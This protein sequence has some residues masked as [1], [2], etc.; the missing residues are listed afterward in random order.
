VSVLT[1]HNDNARTGQNLF[2]GVLTPVNVQAA[3]LGKLFADAVDG[4]VYA[5]PLYMPNVAIPGR[6]L[7]RQ[8]ARLLACDHYH[9]RFAA[10]QHILRIGE[11][12]LCPLNSA[13]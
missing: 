10:A 5:Q 13:E 2:E 4:Y 6:G 11:H 7:A 12:S 9:G 8:R 1:Y 3:T